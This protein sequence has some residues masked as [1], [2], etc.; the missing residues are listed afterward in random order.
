LKCSV[1]ILKNIG[2][3]TLEKGMIVLNRLVHQV[4]FENE[5][6]GCL[7]AGGLKYKETVVE[8]I[9]QAVGAF[10]GL[11]EG[12]NVDKMVVKLA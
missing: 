1:G 3:P 8:G 4:E 5:V 7:R 10:I 12:K 6:G 9:E 2:W 11:F